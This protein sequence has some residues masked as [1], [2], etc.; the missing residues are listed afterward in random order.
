MRNFAL[1]FEDLLAWKRAYELTLKIY[2]LTSD[3]PS[4]EEFGLKSQMRRSAVSIISNIAEGF[5]RRGKKDQIRFYNMA[6]SS[7]EELKCQSRLSRDLN[8]F[9][10]SEYGEIKDMQNESG[11]LLNGWIKSQKISNT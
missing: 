2:K 3:F 4:N 6:E 10:E 8:Y 5:K 1:T 9:S 11:K 7:L